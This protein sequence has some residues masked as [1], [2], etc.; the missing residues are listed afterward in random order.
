M[1]NKE[2]REVSYIMVSVDWG[3]HSQGWFNES[4]KVFGNHY[5]ETRPTNEQ[6][7]KKNEEN[8]SFMVSV[9]WGTH[10]QGWFESPKVSGNHGTKSNT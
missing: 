1:N 7:R 4:P 3:T 2:W 8:V 9:A 5:K 6:W 10:P